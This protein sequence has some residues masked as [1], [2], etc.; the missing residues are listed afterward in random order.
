MPLS[1][2]IIIYLT[3][4]QTGICLAWREKDTID[5]AIREGAV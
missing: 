3:P 2:G 4:F 1:I 5:V